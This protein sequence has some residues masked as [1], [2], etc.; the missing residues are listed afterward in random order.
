MGRY[1][2]AL[3]K[4]GIRVLVVNGAVKFKGDVPDSLKP[5]LLT[6]IDTIL[7]E[8]RAESQTPDPGRRTTDPDPAPAAPLLAAVRAKR[9]AAC[10]EDPRPDL[11]EDSAQWDQL[12]R[13]AAKFPD[14]AGALHGFRCVGAR[15]RRIATGWAVFRGDD[16]WWVDEA[17]FSADYAKWIIGGTDAVA[18]GNSPMAGLLSEVTE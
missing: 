14:L 6:N 8:L 2:K 13:A 4:R 12:L 10:V 9:D 17:E 18:R 15:I 5:Q 1:L 16:G 7:A 11:A 3:E